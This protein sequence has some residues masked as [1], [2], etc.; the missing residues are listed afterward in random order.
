MLAFGGSERSVRTAASIVLKK[1]VELEEKTFFT[2]SE[3]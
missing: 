2:L 1:E 3:I